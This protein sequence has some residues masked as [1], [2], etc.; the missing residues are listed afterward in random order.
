MLVM[1]T[2]W[3]PAI[4]R[5][6]DMHG[7]ICWMFLWENCIQRRTVKF[8]HDFLSTQRWCRSKPQSAWDSRTWEAQKSLFARDREYLRRNSIIM[9]LS[10]ALVLSGHAGSSSAITF[11]QV[12]EKEFRLVQLRQ[13]QLQTLYYYKIHSI[14]LIQITDKSQMAKTY[15]LMKFLPWRCHCHLLSRERMRLLLRKRR[16]AN[17]CPW[18]SLIA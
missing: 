4:V 6:H 10:A 11:L 7:A 2:C 16:H 8:L 18:R 14:A 13:V 5:R 17:C 12:G 9:E 15:A 1:E 3:F